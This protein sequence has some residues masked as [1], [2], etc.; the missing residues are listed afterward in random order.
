LV[1]PVGEFRSDGL[2][3][4]SVDG[5]ALVF[6]ERPEDELEDL[7]SST[8]SPFPA[9]FDSSR[10]TSFPVPMSMPFTQ[11]GALAAS[12]PFQTSAK[13]TLNPACQG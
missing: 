4:G 3:L 2:R 1:A 12:L 10:L 5:T 8:L 7:T 11:S 13:R 9:T 6:V